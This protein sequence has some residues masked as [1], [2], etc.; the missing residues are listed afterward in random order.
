MLKLPDLEGIGFVEFL[1]DV[2]IFERC[3][4]IFN[5]AFSTTM[6]EANTPLVEIGESSPDFC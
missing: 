3:L 2:K 5:T 6:S 1:L 4:K